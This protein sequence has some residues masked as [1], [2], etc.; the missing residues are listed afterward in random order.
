MQASSKTAAIL[1]SAKEAS[2]LLAVSPRK[3]WAMTFEEEP[4]LP[5]IR[6]GRGIRYAVA[7]LE[8]WVNSNRKGGND[9]K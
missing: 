4:S 1:V 6:C 5:Y 8:Q 2:R 3:L 9:A 7:D